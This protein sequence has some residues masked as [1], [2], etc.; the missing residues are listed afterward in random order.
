MFVTLCNQR[1]G[2]LRYA[3]FRMLEMKYYFRMLS[4]CARLISDESIH[5]CKHESKTYMKAKHTN[6][7][8]SYVFA[9]AMYIFSENGSQ[10]IEKI[11]VKVGLQTNYFSYF[12]TSGTNRIAVFPNI[13]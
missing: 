1:N 12:M 3:I 2:N 9:D 7:Q 4:R 11:M 5:V 6:I 13:F 8:K 10:S